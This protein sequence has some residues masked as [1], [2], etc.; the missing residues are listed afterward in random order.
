MKSQLLR[1]IEPEDLALLYEIENDPLMWE[2][3]GTHVPYSEYTLRQYIEQ[4]TNDLTRDLQLRLAIVD[5]ELPV[6]VSKRPAIGF[7]DLQNYD[8]LH[9]RA[10]VGIVLHGI[11][12]G[13]G[14]ATQAL[15]ALSCYAH[16]QFD[17]RVL[18]AIVAE[19]NASALSLFSRA[20][21][22]ETC[23]LPSWIRVGQARKDAILFV[24][25][26]Q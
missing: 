24:R 20:Q 1:A 9:N 19:G 10:E 14:I 13:K 6:E 17:I 15:E 23:T 22:Q 4:Q 2:F 7:A 21:F 3:G 8:P 11:Y 26:F 5:P 18:Y 12:R 16:E 25:V